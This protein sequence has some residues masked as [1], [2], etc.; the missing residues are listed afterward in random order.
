VSRPAALDVGEICALLNARAAEYAPLLLA[1]GR[2][3][4][5]R[6]Y[7]ETNSLDDCPKPDGGYS[8]KVELTGPRK[9]LW[10]DHATGQGGDLLELAMIREHGGDKGRAVA[11]AKSELRLDDMDPQR[12]ERVRYQV[13]QRELAADAEHAK[14][15]EAKRRG[16]LALWLSGQ[17]IA[18][19]PGER[20]LE[21]RGIDLAAIGQWPGSLRYH[22]EVW[23]GDAGVKLPAIVA[24]MVTPAGVQVAT[25]RTWLG[26]DP[27]TRAWV[28]ADG[29]DLGVPRGNAKKVL[30]KC[31]GAFIPIA[32]GASGRSMGTIS[33]VEPIYV[34]EGIEDAL[35]VAMTRPGLRVI[36]AYSLGNLGAI[37]FPAAI[38][39]IVIVADRDEKPKSVDA[40][41]RAI[42]KQQARG[43]RVQLVMPPVGVKDINDWLRRGDDHE[44]AA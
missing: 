31:G 44:E 29:A 26:R 20:Y 14:V 35:C 17:P 4:A 25:H 5:C 41:E 32:K 18:G 10:R 16:A 40:L 15:V 23:N 21:H 2:R 19:T 8:L 13:E 3:S 36:A 42:A 38:D 24:T 28:K 11:W 37:E 7:W 9:G 34:T 43:K 1:N 6:R 12:I 30:G 39:P 33:E 27:R 22:D